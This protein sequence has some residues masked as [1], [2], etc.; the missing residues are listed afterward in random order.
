MELAGEQHACRD[1]N[2]SKHQE[3]R[4]DCG[5]ECLVVSATNAGV[6]PNAMMVESFHAFLAF[7]A[8]L[9]ARADRGLAMATIETTVVLTARFK[10]RVSWINSHGKQART[11][12]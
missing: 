4:Q 5:K 7:P 12:S 6:E 10:G 3:Q 9:A 8:M 2:D 11:G 1:H